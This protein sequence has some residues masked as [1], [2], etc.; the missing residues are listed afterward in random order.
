VT[1]RAF[2]RLLIGALAAIAIVIICAPRRERQPIGAGTAAESASAEPTLGALPGM[3]ALY[4]VVSIG[5][6]ERDPIGSVVDARLYTPA[7]AA[8]PSRLVPAPHRAADAPPRDAIQFA[9]PRPFAPAYLLVV[10]A[11]RAQTV[12]V[13][14]TATGGSR[15]VFS[16]AGGGT[17]DSETAGATI[18]AGERAC[19]YVVPAFAGGATEVRKYLYGRSCDDRLNAWFAGNTATDYREPTPITGRRDPAGT[20]L[21]PVFRPD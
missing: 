3:D 21:D 4:V 12:L 13:N 10:T 18:A 16:G 1:P 17:F 2:A 20:G 14:T 15:A 6:R 5:V 11:A 8:L 7:G 9:L 19:F